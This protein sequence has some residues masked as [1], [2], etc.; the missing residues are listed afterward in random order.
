MTSNPKISIITACYNSEKFLEKC[1]QSVISQ[2]YT[3]KEFIIIDNESKDN[4]PIILEKYKKYIDKII[5]EKDSGISDA[6]NKGVKNS[7]GD[8]L[9]FLGSDD[10]LWDE[11]VL[12]TIASSLKQNPDTLF[13]GRVA[14]V[15]IDSS[16][17][18][19]YT[20]HK[21]FKKLDLLFYLNLPHQGLFT[22][23]S[24]FN[25]YGLF[26]VNLKYSMDYE[27]LL[28]AF[29][30]M[31]KIYTSNLIVCAWREGGIGTN[32]TLDI[33]AEYNFIKAKNNVAPKIILKFINI[34]TIMKYK[35]KNL[36]KKIT[37]N[38]G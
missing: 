6:F 23:R 11:N 36:F 29:H 30:N 7:T 38:I 22:P 5:I 19:Y 4:T 34:Y 9:Y 37:F 14:R 25:Q 2:T 3:N 26:D 33:F 20:K 32:K 15:A 8:Y 28:R 31:P 18:L 24:Y 35:L 12:N 21:E 17:V 10:Y 27:L 1:I 16:K 13:C